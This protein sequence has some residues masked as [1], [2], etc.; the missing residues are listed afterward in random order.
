MRTSLETQKNQIYI[1][2]KNSFLY[3]NIGKYHLPHVWDVVMFNTAEL[4]LIEMNTIITVAI[5]SATSG[6]TSAKLIANTCQHNLVGITSA[7][8]NQGS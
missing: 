5:P 4:K 7:N 8:I 2:V 3:K 6:I 1:G